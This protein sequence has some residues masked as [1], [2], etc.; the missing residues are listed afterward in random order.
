MPGWKLY[1]VPG[2]A[3]PM[4]LSPEHAE[5]LGATETS[6]PDASRPSRGASKADW[7]DYA[8][9]QGMDPVAAESATRAQLIEQYG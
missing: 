6:E 5:E 7:A 8:K 4:H 9:S 3:E 2:Y 1:D